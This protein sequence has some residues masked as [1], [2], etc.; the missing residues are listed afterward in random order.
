[1][2]EAL[3]TKWITLAVGVCDTYMA[4]MYGSGVAGLGMEVVR[5][6]FSKVDCFCAWILFFW[7]DLCSM[8]SQDAGVP[9]SARDVG[10]VEL[11]W[12]S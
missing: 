7:S 4:N 6:L 2:S 3:S 10:A 9:V 8:V 5:M 12:L 1:M 11:L